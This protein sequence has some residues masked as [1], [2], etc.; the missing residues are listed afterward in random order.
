MKRPT[1]S[2]WYVTKTS[3]WYVSLKSHQYVSKTSP[4]STSLRLTVLNETLNNVAVVRLHHVSQLRCCDTLL[5][6][7]CYVF[8]LLCHYLHLVGFHISFNI[9]SRTEIFQYQPGGKQEEQDYKLIAE[10]L[11]YLKATTYINNIC[12]I[13]CVHMFIS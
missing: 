5:V 9:Q 1:M 7:L 8:K 11:L 13:Y 12:N 6:D 10:L 4:I 2:Q 3:Q